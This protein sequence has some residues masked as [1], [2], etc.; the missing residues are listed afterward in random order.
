MKTT[1]RIIA[2]GHDRS[3]LTPEDIEDAMSGDPVL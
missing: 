1:L 2:T 3:Y